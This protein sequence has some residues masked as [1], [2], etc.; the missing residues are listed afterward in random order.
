MKKPWQIWSIYALVVCL[1][2]AA[3]VWLTMQINESDRLREEDRLQT[4]LARQE[5]ELQERISSALYRMDFWAA[6]IIAQ[7]SSRPFFWYR[8]FYPASYENPWTTKGQTDD[9]L[10]SPLMEERPDYVVLHFQLDENNQAMSPQ[11]P[12]GE[13]F[14]RASQ[15]GILF[16][17]FEETKKNFAKALDI[18][19]FHTIS[20]ACSVSPMVEADGITFQSFFRD[21]LAQEQIREG[22]ATNDF[23]SSN[24]GPSPQL[25][26]NQK[27]QQQI[28]RSI[29]R[30]NQEF[31]QRAQGVENFSSNKLLNWNRNPIQTSETSVVQISTMRPLWIKD[32]LILARSVD[33]GSNK[34]VQCCWLDWN[35]IK[36][37]LK[38]ETQDVLPNANFVPVADNEPLQLGNI[39]ATLPVRLDV[40]RAGLLDEL[41]LKAPQSPSRISGLK[42]SLLVAWIS[43]AFAA[44][45][46][47]LVLAGVTRLSERRAAFVSAVTHEL[48]TPLTT[49]RM[50]S[51]MLAERM[52]PEERAAEYGQTMKQEADR[53][54]NL[55]ENVLQYA[56]LENGRNGNPTEETQTVEQLLA[57]FRERLVQRCRDAGLELVVD[58]GD[59]SNERIRVDATKVEQI[60]FNLVD[61]AC[62][63]AANSDPAQVLLNVSRRAG[64]ILFT[65]QDFGPGVS[66]KFQ[67]RLFQPFC[68]SDQDVAD[69]A[70]GVGLG[71]A[72]CQR[73]ARSLGGQVVLAKSPIGAKF[74]LELPLGKQA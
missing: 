57:R 14:E 40:D 36:E 18:C 35:K 20:A 71:L 54:A 26:D 12:V 74:I 29:E 7:E 38:L 51:E 50:Y 62:K 4:E 3:L 70:A 31:L 58:S 11:V 42:S 19:N 44:L 17:G 13:T 41:A 37:R 10:V 30:G 43:F 65:V 32:Q 33:Q 55:V 46:A 16:E 34:Y 45:A 47:G 15:M 52:V 5:A 39:M 48:R 2:S 9:T 24:E 72:L 23:N 21:S 53:L 69:S 67:R 28:S 63:Y 68:K 22:S 49:F 25:A 60:L 1:S 61:N 56:R 6:P 66:P 73:M 64:S 27:Q 59:L 8:S